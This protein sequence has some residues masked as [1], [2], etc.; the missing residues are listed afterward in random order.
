MW[1]PFLHPPKK[2]FLQG[3]S[4]GNSSVAFELLIIKSESRFY[5]S[6]HLQLFNIKYKFVYIFNCLTSNINF[7][8]FNCLTSNFCFPKNIFFASRRGRMLMDARPQFRVFNSTGKM[9]TCYLRVTNKFLRYRI[10]CTNILKCKFP[11]KGI[12]LTRLKF[13][14]VP[15]EPQ[16]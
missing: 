2:G 13:F 11:T 6:V 8:N 5:K 15:R 12:K 7:F 16:L 10:L 14:E 1:R 3:R 9:I 4:E